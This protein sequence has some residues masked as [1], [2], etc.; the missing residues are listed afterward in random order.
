MDHQMTVRYLERIGFAPDRVGEPNAELL[1][2]LHLRHQE[3]VPF[4]N[5]SIHLDEPI[6]LDEDALVDKIVR[7]RRGGFCY[8]LGGA[9]AA[10]L[11]ALGFRVE[12]RAARVFGDGGRLGIPFDHLALMVELEERWLADV[13][14]GRHTSYPLLLDAPD[15]Q[16]DPGG[17]FLI[18]DQDHGDVDVLRDGVPQYRMERHPRSLEEFRVGAWWNST[19]P[20]SHFTQGLTCSL[21]TP[22]GRVTL[23]GDRL[24]RTVGETRTET[25]LTGEDA[26]RDAYRTIFG[27]E[28]D[29]LPKAP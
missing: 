12:H 3:A 29:R 9:F 6:V 24:I 26:I 19:A 23:S 10:L 8:E 17:K 21:L 27:F 22:D 20:A 14:F 15:A 28:L 7:R 1:R 18:V 4:E 11:A 16:D 13:G 25:V 2:E 5:L